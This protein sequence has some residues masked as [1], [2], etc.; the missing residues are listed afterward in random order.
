MLMELLE[1]FAAKHMQ[2]DAPSNWREHLWRAS[3]PQ[4]RPNT[5]CLALADGLLAM[6]IDPA[7]LAPPPHR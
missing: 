2:G 3:Q 5:E 4:P 1:R 7:E 6:G